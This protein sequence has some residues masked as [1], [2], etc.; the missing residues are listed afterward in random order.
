MNATEHA[1]DRL[2]KQAKLIARVVILLTDAKGAPAKQAVVETLT[3][4]RYGH[5]ETKQPVSRIVDYYW[6][7]LTDL[8]FMQSPTVAVEP[9]KPVHQGA[10]LLFNHPV[11]AN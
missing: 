5:L 10:A 7:L 11:N 4:G 6:K 1:Q 9:V 3:E 2:P 8:G